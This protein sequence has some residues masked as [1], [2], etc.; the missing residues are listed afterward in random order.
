MNSIQT[1]VTVVVGEHCDRLEQFA[2]DQLCAL[3]TINFV[4]ESCSQRHGY[5]HHSIY[6]ELDSER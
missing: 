4:K 2:A 1:K 6:S 5:P 3:Y